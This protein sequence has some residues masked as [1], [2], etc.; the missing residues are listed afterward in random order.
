MPAVLLLGASSDMATAIAR[1]FAQDKYDIILAGRNEQQLSEFKTDI[2]IRYKVKAE[3]VKTKSAT[4]SANV[5]QNPVQ[6]LLRLNI[7]S[8]T[9]QT[10]HIVISNERGNV[11]TQQNLSIN[12]G[13]TNI[14]LPA[15]KWQAGVYV[16]QLMEN[17]G[18]AVSISVLK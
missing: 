9:N 17:T 18:A 8:L 10:L 4:F 5:L 2:E 15:S 12:K 7:K 3:A 6:S 14:N 16:I 11:I 1:K 13:T